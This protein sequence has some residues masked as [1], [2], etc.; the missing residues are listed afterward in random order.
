MAASGAI[1]STRA[2]PPS[3]TRDQLLELYYYMGLTRT[4]EERLVNL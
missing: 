4:L 3:L 1:A 2:A